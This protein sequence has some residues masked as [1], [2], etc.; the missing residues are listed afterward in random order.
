MLAESFR[1]H[2]TEV[3][4]YQMHV[5]SAVLSYITRLRYLYKSPVGGA[6]WAVSDGE[7]REA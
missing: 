4:E 2:L 7:P 3:S 5:A 1:G 6:V